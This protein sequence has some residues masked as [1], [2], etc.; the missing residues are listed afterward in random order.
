MNEAAK[1]LKTHTN[2]QSFSKY[3]TDVAHFDCEIKAAFWAKEEKLL[4]FHI[5]ANRFLRGMVR[6]IVGTMLEIG[7]QKVSLAAFEQIIQA[8]DRKAAKFA[9]PPEGLFLTKVIYNEND[10]HLLW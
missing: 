6:A 4:V 9:A 5:T 1:H 7:K 10:L 8:K 3:H 2:F